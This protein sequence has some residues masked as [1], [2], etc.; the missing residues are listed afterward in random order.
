MKTVKVSVS[1]A[2]V[3]PGSDRRFPPQVSNTHYEARGSLSTGS[4]AGCPTYG[5]KTMVENGWC[6]FT[7]NTMPSDTVAAVGGSMYS[8]ASIS[9][10]TPVASADFCDRL[11]LKRSHREAEKL[12]Q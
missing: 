6:C 1:I 7:G 8:Q 9:Q 4:P 5:N 2:Q 11:T 3:E 12:F 10:I